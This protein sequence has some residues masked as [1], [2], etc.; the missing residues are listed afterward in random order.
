MPLFD[1]KLVKKNLPRALRKL[2]IDGTSPQWVRIL[3]DACD[4]RVKGGG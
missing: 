1:L 2:Q 4:S 3:L